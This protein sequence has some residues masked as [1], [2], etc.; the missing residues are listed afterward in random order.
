M[1]PER[2]LHI[3]RVFQSALDSEPADRKAFLDSACR[4]DPELRDEVESLLALEKDSGFTSPAL[5]EGMRVLGAHSARRFE[6]RMIGTYRVQRE[7]GRGGMGSVYLAARDDNTFQKLVAIKIVRGGLEAGD[8]IERFQKERQIL[9]TLDHPNITQL[10][11]GGTTDDGLPYLVMEYIDGDPIDGYCDEHRLNITERLAIFQGVC[12]AVSYAHRNLIVHRDIKPGNVLVT[13]DG[14]P[15]LLDFGIAKLLAP[16]MAPEDQTI[17]KPFTP[18]YASP[19]QVRG[20]PITTASDVYSLGV[21][22]Y[23]LL[24]G[25]RP[26][27]QF[28]ST[29]REIEHAICHEEPEKPSVAIMREVPPA[30]ENEDRVT[31][32]SVSRIREG[33][34][35][36]LR[37]RLQGDLDN[38][39]LMSLRKDPRRRY[40][41][42]EQLSE[43]IRR[44]LAHL[45][46]M[47]RP[48]TRW[49]RAAK[50]LRR[51]KAWVAMGALTSLSLTVGTSVSLWQ[52]HVARQQR[53]RARVEQ[54]KAEQIKAFLEETLTFAS[55]EYASSNPEKNKDAKI[56]EAVEHAARRAENELSGQPEVL[57]EIQST[58]GAVYQA[59]GRYD[60]AESIL[61]SAREK[62]LRLYGSESHEITA[63]SGMLANLLLR[64]GNYPE[65]ESLFRKNIEIERRQAKQGHL[66]AASMA[67]VLGGYGGML[68]G[69]SKPEAEA[70]LKE[71]LQYSSAFSG[72]E[73][74][75]VAMLH[76]DLGNVAYRRGDLDES[77][78]RQRA[79]LEEYRKLPAGT[80]IEMGTTL[81]NL[82][83]ILIRKGRY[84]DA[85]PF[86][87]EGLELRRKLLGNAHPDTGMALFRLSDLLYREGNYAGAQDAANQSVEVFN[88]ALARPQDNPFYANPLLELGL[89]L[90]KM[91]R[92]REAEVHLRQAL[93]IRRRL[94]PKGNQLIGITEG[95]F[96]ECLT[97]QKRYAEAEPLL[98]DSFEIIRSTTVESDSR[99]A[100]AAQRLAVL[101]RSWGKPP[102]AARYEALITPE[103]TRSGLRLQSAAVSK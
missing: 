58:I 9:A 3:E 34:T 80:Y 88:R 52:A 39:A 91:G 38:I 100:E 46:V 27:R 81:S 2:W 35:E 97:M 49:Y 25:H 89:I 96:G 5:E 68:D 78:R 93:E 65:A 64:K 8:F 71:A 43:D 53:D 12:A 44:H 101:Y 67:Y 23:R 29:S 20:S 60:Q 36:K 55:P 42:A 48:N 4:D 102:Q 83:A 76:N 30:R 28:I 57:A 33:T 92:P 16:G 15:R 74:V 85:E 47:A 40:A 24:T 32:S 7:I 75:F 95:A 66:N 79:A 82:G 98:L 37:R 19:E 6:G 62:Y 54:A 1:Q 94:V 31:P 63:V 59:Q 90:D 14:V 26:Y 77:E 18:E 84:R 103:N 69:I 70:Y 21:L 87:R 41:S 13:R 50:L 73:R 61:R 10:L 17:A 45:P 22:L 99:R 56:S 51:H 86:V 72:K 11:D